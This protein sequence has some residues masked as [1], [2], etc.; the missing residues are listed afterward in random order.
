MFSQ[1][2][3]TCDVEM[4]NIHTAFSFSHFNFDSISLSLHSTSFRSISVKTVFSCVFECLRSLNLMNPKVSSID[5]TIESTRS[6]LIGSS[7]ILCVFKKLRAF[8]NVESNFPTSFKEFAEGNSPYTF[9]SSRRIEVMTSFV[10]L[11]SRLLRPAKKKNFHTSLK[12][13]A[14]A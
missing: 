11:F 8:S 14:L 4:L 9:F 3:M 1:R 6:L 13:Y 10:S 12:F 5:S 2:G 7:G